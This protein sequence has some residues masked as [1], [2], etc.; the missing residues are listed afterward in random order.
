MAYHLETASCHLRIRI[1]QAINTT[2]Y[3]PYPCTAGAR[4]FWQIRLHSKAPLRQCVHIAWL[5]STSHFRKNLAPNSSGTSYNSQ[6]SK[7]QIFALKLK[8]A[9]CFLCSILKKFKRCSHPNH[10]CFFFWRPPLGHL[11][12]GR[13]QSL[14]ILQGHE[15]T[16]TC[17]IV[18]QMDGIF[19][20]GILH[21]SV[22]FKPRFR[23]EAV[24]SVDWTF[25]A[26]WQ[27]PHPSVAGPPSS[28]KSDLTGG[29]T[30]WSWIA[31]RCDHSTGNKLCWTRQR[32]SLKRLPRKRVVLLFHMSI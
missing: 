28:L 5:R 31:R 29:F 6:T 23:A 32:F 30:Y 12:D 19:L 15:L 17:S 25:P 16:S 22:A 2:I 18:H 21:P 11:R 27:T 7:S 4:L 10:P 8:I 14:D 13:C 1:Q 24:D 20:T 9:L 3:H 26:K